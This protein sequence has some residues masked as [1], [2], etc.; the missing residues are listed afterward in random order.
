MFIKS[1]KNLLS[2][3]THKVHSISRGYLHLNMY[4]LHVKMQI[5]LSYLR[6][7]LII[8]NSSNCEK[9]CVLKAYIPKFTW[10]QLSI[11]FYKKQI[12]FS[13]CPYREQKH[14]ERDY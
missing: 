2:K 11:N 5:V 6:S 9:M 4:I 14:F 13:S 7:R 1:L 3:L 10:L 8:S 12:T